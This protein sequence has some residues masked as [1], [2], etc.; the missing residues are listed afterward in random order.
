MYVHHRNPRDPVYLQNENDLFLVECEFM[1][2]TDWRLPI[3]IPP[4]APQ[5]HEDPLIHALLYRRG[6]RT[7]EDALRFLD[8]APRPV[9][10]LSLLPNVALGVARVRQALAGRERVA[11]FGDYDADGL[12][13]TAILT[14]ALRSVADGPDL[15]QPQVPTRSEGY[16]LNQAAIDAIASTGASLL[17]AVDC[18]ST[19]H[20]QVGYARSRGLDIL[21]IDHHRMDDSGPEGAITIS[22]RLEVDNPNQDLCAAGLAYLF[23]SALAQDGLPITGGPN[24]EPETALIDL[25]AL[26]TVGDSCVLNGTNRDFVRDGL[27][28]INIRPRPA[29]KALLGVSRIDLGTLTAEGI[30]FQLVPRLNSVGRVGSPEMALRLLLTDDYH[31]AMDLARKV[32]ACNTERKVILEQVVREADV[33]VGGDPSLGEAQALVV[34]SQAWSHGVL[35]IA[36][37]KLVERH[38]RPVLVMSDDGEVCKGSARTVDGVDLYAVLSNSRDLIM[39]FGGHTDAAGLTL[40][41]ANVPALR[42]RMNAYLT[43]SGTSF[44]VPRR[45]DIDAEIPASRLT[46]DTVRKLD[47]LRPFGRGN[48]LPK[49][50]IRNMPVRYS[51]V[52]GQNQDHLKLTLKTSMGSIK[53]KQWGG[54]GRLPE[55]Q[56]MG[57]IDVVATLEANHYNGSVTA[58]LTLVDFRPSR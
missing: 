8:P 11:I 57:T 58:E 42:E 2:Q 50:L 30:S 16:G 45:I 9:P 53:A 15:I 49:L 47:V 19:D 27:R 52:M 21:I 35:G 29:I 38:G 56:K 24:G 13:S 20:T 41:T 17:I 31:E 55:F 3:P 48:E 46:L 10:D 54:A 33:I 40:L 25:V 43:A 51:D 28:E 39:H 4:D 22:P 1:M 14:R 44:P 5:L 18:G 36:A 7:W 26:G 32:D 23:V 34:T 6:V 37:S 12:T